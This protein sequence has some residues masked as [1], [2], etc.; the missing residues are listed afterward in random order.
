MITVGVGVGVLLILT[1]NRRLPRTFVYVGG[2]IREW[3]FLSGQFDVRFISFML[4]Y[5]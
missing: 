5:W 2:G 4:N 3:A 1:I